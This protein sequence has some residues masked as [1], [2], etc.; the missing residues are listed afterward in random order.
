MTAKNSV[1]KPAT[2]T[3][4]PPAEVDVLI[5]GAG[6]SGISA[7]CHL[8]QMHPQRTFALLEARNATGGT[9][10]QFRY[11]GIRSDSDLQT[12][13]YRFK[14]WTGNKSLAPGA[15][16]LGYIREAADEHGLADHTWTSHRVD[17]ADWSSEDLRWH[18]TVTNTETDTTFTVKAT[19]L[20]TAA[21]FFSQ[22][23][24]YIPDFPGRDDFKGTFLHPQFWPED[25][26]VRGKKVVVIGSGAT[27]ATLVPA[28]ADDVE[29][30]TMLQRSPGY[31]L[32]FPD[33][34]PIANGLRKAFGAKAGHAI[35][36]WKNIQLY[37]GMYRISQRYPGLA[38]K[39]IRK[40]QE[41]YLGAD[42]DYDTHLTPRYNPWDQRM[43][44]VP[45]GDFL[46]SVGAGKASIVTGHI[47]RITEKGILLKSG[48][49]LEADIIVSATGFDIQPF[50]NIRISVDGD[51][52]P[53]GERISFRGMMLSDVPN[54]S[55][56]IGY[57]T[58]SW[59][60]KSDLVAEHVCRI[61]TMLDEAGAVACVPRPPADMETEQFSPHFRP[62]Y[63]ERNVHLFPK[64][65]DRAPWRSPVVYDEDVREMK[66]KPVVSRDLE[67]LYRANAL[68]LGVDD[69]AE[70]SA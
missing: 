9:W 70:V 26:D 1:S 13:G 52:K 41:S 35:A 51:A 63:I 27:A 6:V 19:W 14:P 18:V 53:F 36:R 47:D 8:Q 56:V 39:F 20:S 64:Q 55:Y 48:E 40:L 68:A 25:L 2:D 37:V 32:P 31:I 69:K 43:C 60:L 4:S 42:F 16:I 15:D 57:T 17:A 11:P 62:G 12:F 23:S 33:V 24:A 66:Y 22:D 28:I 34:D 3:A 46:K 65:G 61:L 38:R 58:N 10:D 59:T 7:A 67:L 49:E 50:G 45:N 21:G 5:V 30:V 29:H 44:L 54:F